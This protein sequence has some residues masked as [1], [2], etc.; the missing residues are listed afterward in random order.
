MGINGSGQG[1]PYRGYVHDCAV[2]ERSDGANT[3]RYVAV[4]LNAKDNQALLDVIVALDDLILNHG[5][6]AQ[7]R[8]AAAAM[9]A[10]R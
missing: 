4:A 8:K 3:H 1:T 2:I 7:R 5:A 10:V 6:L 9:K